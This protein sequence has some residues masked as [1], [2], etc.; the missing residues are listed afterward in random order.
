VN[1]YIYIYIYIY[2]ERERERE[3]ENEPSVLD[4][5]FLE[6]SVGVGG[7]GVVEEVNVAASLQRSHVLLEGLPLVTVGSLG[8]QK[9]ALWIERC[10]LDL[11]LR[12]CS[13]TILFAL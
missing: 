5:G 11:S 8:R 6:V 9:L 4:E 3:R 13:E 1:I 10:V 2:R 7:E 12:H